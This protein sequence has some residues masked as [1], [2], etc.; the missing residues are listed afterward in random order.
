MSLSYTSAHGG[1]LR[2]RMAAGC[3]AGEGCSNRRMSSEF[4]DIEQRL[5]AAAR[6]VREREVT[7]QRK[8]ELRA[9]QGELEGALAGLRDKA[10]AERKD[11]ERLEGMSLGRVLA[12]L[13]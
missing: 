7:S 5:A 6:A 1:Q 9:R 4:G 12:S 10:S 3:G 11:V 8:A 2:W 13:A